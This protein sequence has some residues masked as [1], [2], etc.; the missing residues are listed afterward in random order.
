MPQ[1]PKK[2]LTWADLGAKGAPQSQPS[3]PAKKL[4]WDDLRS[5]QRVDPW[6]ETP[7]ATML[8]RQAKAAAIAPVQ[9]LMQ[10]VEGLSTGLSVA[11]DKINDALGLNSDELRADF[12]SD[13]ASPLKAVGKWSG[14][15]ARALA[16][17]YPEGTEEGT[18]AATGRFVGA[19]AP[20]VAAALV[21]PESL[22]ARLATGATANAF[23]TA[24]DEYLA[25]ELGGADE[26]QKMKAYVGGFGVGGG[27]GLVMQGILSRALSRP[28]A[29]AVRELILSGGVGAGAGAA[30]QALSNVIAAHVAEYDPDRKLLEGVV[31]SGEA[32]GLG[33]AL[34]SGLVRGYSARGARMKA[35]A[36]KVE[37]TRQTEAQRATEAQAAMAAEEAGQANLRKVEA[38]DRAR[39]EAAQGEARE[40]AYMARRESEAE[41]M[42]AA[43]EE[44]ART[45]EFEA[46]SREEAARAEAEQRVL[47]DRDET[48][49]MAATESEKLA[50]AQY[51]ERER[52]ESERATAAK[53]DIDR[54]EAEF[55]ARQAADLEQGRITREQAEV[56]RVAEARRMEGERARQETE[57]RT[58]YEARAATEAQR[59]ASAQAE[60]NAR[61]KQGAARRKP[62]RG[63][64]KEGAVDIGPAIDAV[65]NFVRRVGGRQPE[66]QKPLVPED[67]PLARIARGAHDKLEPLTR[68]PSLKGEERSVRHAQARAINAATRAHNTIVVPMAEIMREAGVKVRPDFDPNA[69]P[70]NRQRF[71]AEPTLASYI[72]AQD[73]LERNPR[74]EAM[75]PTQKSGAGITTDEAKQ[76]IA[77]V[78]ALPNAG[79]FYNALDKFYELTKLTRDTWRKTGT[80]SLGLVDFLEQDAPHYAPAKTD[81]EGE[82]GSGK[83]GRGYSIGIGHES[84]RALG[85]TTIPDDPVA[86]A[87]RDLINA[88]E[89]GYAN[90]AMNRVY[91]K[92]KAKALTLIARGIRR[93]S[94]KTIVCVM[95]YEHDVTHQIG[96]FKINDI[97]TSRY[98]RKFIEEF[99][100]HADFFELRELRAEQK[101]PGLL[102]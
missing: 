15:A 32:G 77:N 99:P 97:V 26:S 94:S 64:K 1:E 39:Y 53:A 45:A 6:A 69:S 18:V 51:R 31:Q 57:E 49:R 89:R 98:A 34:L 25:A 85:R 61:P 24:G 82:T 60:I 3:A 84:R 67:H 71:I 43:S 23:Q 72:T 91:A 28:G 87:T 79:A 37:Q 93:Y 95:R 47:A 81:V 70:E 16:K 76:I 68:V 59:A 42:A 20:Q 78:K 88:L 35:E 54:Q 7:P 65:S 74:I 11:A 66:G 12:G 80:E 56:E 63:G 52:V 14:K 40:G 41:G 33:L 38:E 27:T 46:R 5:G 50:A 102:F 2:K 29:S 90:K 100:Q 48:E 30:Q 58:G 36:Q 8:A 4:T 22:L 62:K 83:R 55:Q 19:A 10:G 17:A 86:F 13:A 9:G 73:A 92:F 44:Y 21:A 96:D 75:D 101:R